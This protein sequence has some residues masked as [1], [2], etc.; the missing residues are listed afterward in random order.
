MRARLRVFPPRRAFV[1]PS[2]RARVHRATP[3][4]WR[5]PARSSDSLEIMHDKELKAVFRALTD[6]TL[7]LKDGLSTTSEANERTALTRHLAA[8]A[9]IYAVL[10]QTGQVSAIRDL[11]ESEHRAHGWSFL[12]GAAGQAIAARWQRFSDV[13]GESGPR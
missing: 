13:V 3:P 10:H 2:R 5:Y 11:V 6:Y 4:T 7:T 12:G 1:L 9:G 8:A